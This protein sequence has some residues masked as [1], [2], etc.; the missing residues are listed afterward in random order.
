MRGSFLF[1][2]AFVVETGVVVKLDERS[3]LDEG[4]V[5]IEE[6]CGLERLARCCKKRWESQRKRAVASR[7]LRVEGNPSMTMA[8]L[9][10]ALNGA[11]AVGDDDDKMEVEGGN[12]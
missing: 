1:A 4:V 8:G 3:F 12:C 10:V 9:G 6:T 7:L 2:F 5:L 11:R